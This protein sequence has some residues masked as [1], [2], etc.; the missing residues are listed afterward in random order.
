MIR[1]TTAL[2]A[3][4]WLVFAAGCAEPVAPPKSVWELLECGEGL[5]RPTASGATLQWVAAEPLEARVSWGSE[6]DGLDHVTELSCSGPTELALD[7]L[8]PDREAFVRLELRRPGME[9]WLARPLRSF[10]TAR[11]AGSTFRVGLLADTHVNALALYPGATENLR[12]TI[13]RCLAD[14]L[15]FAV[16]LGDEAGVHF[17]GDTTSTM[18]AAGAVE[19]WRLWRDTYTPLLE[20]LPAFMA[21]GN[22]EGEAGYYR[23]LLTP[24]G[25][26]SLQRWGTSARKQYLLNPLPTTYP[27]GGEAQGFVDPEEPSDA[28][29]F[30]N[31]SPLQNYFAWTWGDALFVVLDVHRY[32]QGEALVARSEAPASEVRIGVDDWTLGPQQL[33]WLEATLEGSSARHKVILAHHLMGGWDYDLEG[34]DRDAEYKYGRG[35]A[36]YARKGEQARITELMQRHGA[37]YFFY[38]HDHVFAHQ[39]AEGVEFVCCG[40]PSYLSPRWWRAPGWREAYGQLKSR[41]AREFLATIGYTRLTVEPQR[42][43]IEYVRP[44][45]APMRGENVAPTPDGVVYRWDSSQPSPVVELVR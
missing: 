40:R 24:E 15:D 28:G 12:A 41:S 26:L 14:E 30:S 34:L 38:G 36:R 11:A 22:H 20:S 23:E 18:S 19:R 16:F 33:A 9:D 2:A 4:G 27:E 8:E 10:R 13:E 45:L 39:A 21:L 29:P 44:A 5:F 17:Y 6:R 31:R 7:G 43:V 42:V 37:R 1:P 3:L 35:G 25:P 32:T